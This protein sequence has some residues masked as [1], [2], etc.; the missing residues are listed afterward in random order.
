[1]WF[2]KKEETIMVESPLTCLPLVQSNLDNAVHNPYLS[3]AFDAS[4]ELAADSKVNDVNSP[5]VKSIIF[6][7]DFTKTLDW[8]PWFCKTDPIIYNIKLDSDV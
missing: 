3:V 5:L 7:H 1:M 4:K 2:A 8:T 6:Y